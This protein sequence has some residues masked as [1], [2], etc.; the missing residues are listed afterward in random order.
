MAKV[1]AFIEAAP[2]RVFEVL[3]NGWYYPNWVVGTSHMRAVDEHWPDV[4]SKL[5]HAS[6]IWPMA[7]RDETEVE[8]VVPGSR[9]VMMVKGRPLGEARVEI[10]L[11]REGGGTRVVL[12][13]EPV[14]GPGAWAHNPV[15]ERLLH[16]RNVEV[17]ARLAAIAEQRS[18]P[19][20]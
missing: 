4:G 13:E 1:E 8:A 9:L 7:L 10:N 3:S 5:F 11:H 14:R 12:T 17:L 20:D 19:A 2:E 16:R 15:T 6:G 18:T